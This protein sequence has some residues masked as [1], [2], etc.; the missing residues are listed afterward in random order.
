[1]I[2]FIFDILEAILSIIIEGYNASGKRVPMWIRVIMLLI[3][4][5]AYLLF[6]CG[7]IYLG[8]MALLDGEIVAG[9][10]F[11]AIAIFVIVGGIYETR[12]MFKNRK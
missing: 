10:I 1:M 4:L 3:V 11:M 8:Y 6:G 9:I 7:S 12:K 5:G 2:E